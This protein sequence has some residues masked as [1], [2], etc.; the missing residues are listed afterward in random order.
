MNKIAIILSG[1][2]KFAHRSNESIRKWFPSADVFAHIWDTKAEYINRSSS[3]HPTSYTDVWDVSR[4]LN[5]FKFI[6]YEIQDFKDKNDYWHNGIIKEYKEIGV[7]LGNSHEGIEDFGTSITSMFYSLNQA[8]KLKQQHEI[9]NNFK[10]DAVIR[11]RF[12]SDVYNWNLQISNN[13]LYIPN[14]YDYA[15]DGINDQFCYGDSQVM[16]EACS[17]YNGLD[18]IVRSTKIYNPEF[19]FAEHLRRCNIIPNRISRPSANDIT[20]YIN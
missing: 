20:V 11:M 7:N 14:S 4:V 13:M 19:C 17:C 2:P 9:E 1:V 8:L 10:Y 15:K 3:F 5:N 6:K 12:D 16:D 18:E